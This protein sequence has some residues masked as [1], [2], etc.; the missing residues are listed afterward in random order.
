MKTGLTLALNSDFE[1]KIKKMLIKIAVLL[2]ICCHSLEANDEI[3]SYVT[4]FTQSANKYLAEFSDTENE[5][6]WWN[7]VNGPNL[8]NLKNNIQ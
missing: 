4:D 5:L 7:E 8:E 6:T 3:S 2:L 1:N